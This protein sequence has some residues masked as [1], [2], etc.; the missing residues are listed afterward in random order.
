MIGQGQDKTQIFTRKKGWA[1][2]ARRTTGK[3]RGKKGKEITREKQRWLG[4][5][6]GGHM[7]DSSCANID[8]LVG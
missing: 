5:V 4:G 6:I 2:P 8:L 7:S 3:S 1:A